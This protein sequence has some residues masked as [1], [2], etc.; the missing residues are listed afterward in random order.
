MNR[1][2]P[3]LVIIVEVVDVTPPCY[4][5]MVALPH[6]KHLAGEYGKVRISGELGLKAVDGGLLEATPGI[7]DVAGDV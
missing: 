7:K 4:E 1:H 2:V 3:N 5:A 6:I